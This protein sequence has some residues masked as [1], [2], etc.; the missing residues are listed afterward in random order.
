MT[1]IF[2]FFFFFF[3]GINVLVN[4][5]SNGVWVVSTSASSACGPG[6]W[7]LRIAVAGAHRVLLLLQEQ[8]SSSTAE[9]VLV[10]VLLLLLVVM[11][12]AVLT[13]LK[14][15]LEYIA[16]RAVAI[17]LRAGVYNVF[18]WKFLVWQCYIEVFCG[19]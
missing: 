3:Q 11:A 15:N 12:A 18:T 5:T 4:L 14:S 10:E 8:H 16:S 17:R 19:R 13:M 7:Q 1:Q 2:F 9:V 6:F